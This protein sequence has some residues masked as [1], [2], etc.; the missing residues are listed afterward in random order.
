[1][2]ALAELINLSEDKKVF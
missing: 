2:Y 1:M